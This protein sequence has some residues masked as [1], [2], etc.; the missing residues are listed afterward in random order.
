MGGNIAMKKVL[1]VSPHFPPLNTADLHRVRQSLPYFAELDWEVVVICVNEAYVESYSVDPFLMLTIPPAIVVHKVKAC[2]IKLARKFGLGSLSMRSYWQIK[3][4]G[5]ELLGKEHFD[6]VYFSTTA[7]HVMAL[8]P[9]WKKKFE[10]PFILDIQDPWRNDFYLDKPASKRP[11]K[12]FISYKIDKWLEAYTVPKADGIISVSKK[13]C[14]TF[15]MRYPSVKKEQ[16]RVITFGASLYDVEIMK[17]YVQKSEHIKFNNEKFNLVYI[18]RGGH[19]MSF[20][21]QIIFK[22]LAKGLIEDEV[23][24]KG[25]MILEEVIQEVLS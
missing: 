8:G 25:L 1:I 24:Y 12:F 15:I 10:V 19:D 9:G 6:L 17:K 18:G 23:L 22:A 13:Y 5:N 11:P 21:L 4:K 20:A 7:F 14:D 3:R 16:C 2:P